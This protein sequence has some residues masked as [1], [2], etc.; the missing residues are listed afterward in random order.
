MQSKR[1]LGSKTA[2]TSHTNYH[3]SM[4][5][6]LK[7]TATIKFNITGSENKFKIEGVTAKGVYVLFPFS[8]QEEGIPTESVQRLVLLTEGPSRFEN[9]Y[10]HAFG[11]FITTTTQLVSSYFNLPENYE[12][13]L[14]AT[15]HPQSF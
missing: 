10:P 14:C 12:L 9:E 11:K 1:T 6:P 4:Q 3:V 8:K 7:T 15:L 2:P 13:C 5:N